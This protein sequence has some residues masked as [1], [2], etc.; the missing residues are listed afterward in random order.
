MAL[1]NLVAMKEMSCFSPTELNASDSPEV[2]DLLVPLFGCLRQ[3][4]FENAAEVTLCQLRS[5]LKSVFV[6]VFQCITEKFFKCGRFPYEESTIFE[7][8]D[9][10][11]DRRSRNQSVKAINIEKEARMSWKRDSLFNKVKLNELQLFDK[12]DEFEVFFHGTS[13]EN[14]TAIIKGIKLEE[15]GKGKEFSDGDGFYVFNDFYE[16][17]CWA[18]STF[19]DYDSAVLVFRVMRMKLRGDDNNNGLDLTGMRQKKEWQELVNIF[20]TAKLSKIKKTKKNLKGYDF[21]E[22]PVAA[23]GRED[24]EEFPTPKGDS[25]QLCLRSERCVELFNRSLCAVVYFNVAY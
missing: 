10:P 21:I 8:F 12:L 25:Y 22:G 16:A 15:G 5:S 23:Y 18:A 19:S 7:W 24:Y 3:L 2:E 13:H 9:L 14:A 4:K 17:R 1:V 6:P 20:R 11:G